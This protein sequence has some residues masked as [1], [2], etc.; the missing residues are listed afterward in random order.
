LDIPKLKTTQRCDVRD[1]MAA[2]SNGMGRCRYFKSL[3][4]FRYTGRFFKS[5]RY[6]LSVFK[7]SRYRFGIFGIATCVT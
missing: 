7:I 4:V 5:V 2:K 1:F 3:S 6:L